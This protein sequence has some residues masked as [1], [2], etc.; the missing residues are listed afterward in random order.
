MWRTDPLVPTDE[1]RW[2]RRVTLGATALFTLILT[3]WRPW[4]LFARGGFSTDFY[5]AQADAFWHLRL[6]VPADVA[7]IEGFSIDGDTYLYYGPFLAVARMPIAVFGGWADGRLTRL[8]MVIAF[9]CICSVTFHLARRAARLAGAPDGAPWRPALLVAAVALSPALALAGR[10]SVYHETELWAFVLILATFVALI[11]VLLEPAR[12]PLVLAGAAAVATVLTRASIGFGALTALAITGGWLLWRD[13]RLALGAVT[14]AVAGLL[15]Y[16]GINIAKFGTPIDLPANRQVLT[17]LS[18]DRAAWL[19]GNDGSFFGLRFLP[20]TVFHYARPDAIRF[21]RLVPF[22]R[23]GPRAHEFGSYPLESNTP[24]SSLTASATLLVVMALIGIVLLARGRHWKFTALMVGA[25]VAAAPTLAIGF[26]ANRYLVDLLP[27]LVVPAALAVGRFSTARRGIAIAAVLAL[28]SWG[29]IANTALAV[30]QDGIERPGF[31]ASRYQVDERVFGGPPP[32]VV[33]LDRDDPVPR[34]GVVGI[35][36]ACA[37]L[38]IASQDEWVPLELAD[39][40]RR[41]SATFDPVTGVGVLTNGRGET[42]TV[43]VSPDGSSIVTAYRGGDGTTVHGS[44]V[45]SDG[46][47]VD[48]EVTSDPVAGGLLGGLSVAIDGRDVLRAFVAPELAD[49][50]ASDGL[51]ITT[52]SGPG[53]PICTALAARR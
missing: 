9:V 48:V 18:V 51:T 27:L 45:P 21:E 23:F 33:A 2:A 15:A 49:M 30:W 6:G 8:S 37:G 34:D 31:T 17:Q 42:I 13:R 16:I 35:D 22:V 50:N 24:S 28:V 10:A 4:N 47:P 26:I 44:I 43:G 40:V 11:D 41:L 1:Q 32:S 3:R 39:G 7:G 29:A 38:Y 14:T 46:G 20:T 52:P 25:A 12:R 36:G 53:T 19:A 5:D